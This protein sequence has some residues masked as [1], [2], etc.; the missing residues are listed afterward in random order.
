[1]RPSLVL[2]LAALLFASAP[3]TAAE[4]PAVRAWEEAVEI[5]TYVMGPAE[6]NPMFFTPNGYQGASSAVYPYPLL[7]RLGTVKS[8]RTY[9]GLFLENS[10][11]KLSVLPEIGGRLFS[12]VDKTNGYD[13][14]Y[15]QSVIK[16]ALIGMA[17]AWI[18]GG[19]EWNVFHHHRVSTFMPVDS[20]IEEHPD[21]GK[22]LWVGETDLRHRMK[23]IIG[24]TLR[25]DRSYIEATLKIFNRTPFAH[26]FL[27]WANPA[28][29]ANEQ[30][31]V[32]F[33]PGTEFATFHGKNQFSSWPISH[34]VYNGADYTAGVDLSWWKNH[35]KPTSFFA[36]NPPDEFLGGY[37]HGKQ[38]GVMYWADHNLA[39]GKKLWEWGPGPEGRMW[40]RILTDSDGPYIELMA[41]AFSDN[42]PDYSWIQ[43]HEVKI[44][45]QYWYPLRGIGGAKRANLEG[46]LNLEV[47]GGRAK[48]GINSTSEQPGAVVRVAVKGRT[49]L[50]QRAD[51][52]PGTPFVRDIPL[53]AGTL[54]TDVRAS[55]LSATGKELIA[56]QPLPRPSDPMPEPVRKPFPAPR[57]IE[58]SEEVYLTGLRLEQFYDPSA[59]PE[60]YYEEVLRRDPGDLRANVALGTRELRRAL[61]ESAEARL[62]TAVAR[63]SRHYTRPRSGEAQYYLGLALRAQGKL[64]SAYEAFGRAAWDRA[65]SAPAYTAMAEIDGRRGRFA[66]ALGRA[67]QA[68]I[69][70]ALD[71]KILGLQSAFLRRLD[72]AEEAEARAAKALAIDPL[73]FLAANEGILAAMRLGKDVATPQQTLARLMRGADQ[74]FLELATDHANA[75]L[76]DEAIEVLSRHLPASAGPG[77]DPLVLYTLGYLQEQKAEAQKAASSYAAGARLSPDYCFPFRLESIDVLR[78]AIRTQPAD[79]RAHSYLGNLLYDLQPDAAIALWKKAVELEPGLA[80]AHRNLA[81]GLAHTRNDVKSAISALEQ[82]VVLHPSDPQLLF[83]LDELYDAGRASLETRLARLEAHQETVLLKHTSTVRQVMVYVLLERYDEALALLSKRHFHVWEGEGGV[84][85]WYVDAHLRRGERRLAAGDKAGALA[86]F[87]AALVIPD[88]I[89]VGSRIGERRAE[90]LYFIGQAQMALG[91]REKGLASLR[92]AAGLR[93]ATPEMAYYQALALTELG[94]RA[95]AL[96]RLEAIAAEPEAGEGEPDGYDAQRRYRARVSREHYL[97]ALKALGLGDEARARSELDAALTIHPNFL[98]ARVQRARLAKRS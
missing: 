41:G 62:R 52:G 45:K 17:G 76:W 74:S 47:A 14:F 77:V 13:F 22:T 49:V 44:V 12:A 57:D 10:F 70:A 73:D 91:Q 42:Q 25:P 39:P 87:E 53:P 71:T 64:D 59:R 1:M 18:S 8:P 83:E 4:P 31:Q 5:P 88:N 36:W 63:E 21:G 32:L 92:E 84:H 3:L 43:P 56:Y 86:D 51:L 50:E 34:Q 26:S 6:P 67:E 37:D 60:P 80:I 38:A 28:V 46:A 35:P 54:E 23:W 75:G 58:S 78:A 55:L 89:E 98:P 90:V 61:Y 40:D 93:N 30:Y 85:D 69:T 33:P 9:K 48:V 68:G 96:T 29:H 20:S 81:F 16:P 79:A 66:D 11:V 7:D 24:L 97:A 2:T 19:I 65:F 82:A 94:D 95:A 72:R 27:Y 15:R